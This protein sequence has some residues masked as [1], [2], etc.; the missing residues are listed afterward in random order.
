MLT[1]QLGFGALLGSVSRLQTVHGDRLFLRANP[2]GENSVVDPLDHLVWAGIRRLKGTPYRIDAPEDVGTC[3]KILKN[4]SSV[5]GVVTRGHRPHALHVLR[6]LLSEAL[7]NRRCIPRNEELPRNAEGCTIQHFRG[8]SPEVLF[9][10]R[11]Q[12]EKNGRQK[13]R[14]WDERTAHQ[15]SL[16]SPMPPFDH[17]IGLG[18]VRRRVD[19][20][21]SNP[22]CQGGEESGLE[23]GSLVSGD[24]QRRAIGANPVFVE[25]GSHGARLDV[26]E[27]DSNRPSRETINDREAITE[28]TDQRHGNQIHVYMVETAVRDLN[29]IRDDLVVPV[30]LSALAWYA[31]ARPA[32]R[33]LSNLWPNEL[34]SQSPG[35]NSATGMG[36]AVDHIEGPSAEA[37]G[38]VRSHDA[39]RDITPDGFRADGE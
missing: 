28:V 2:D 34:L 20:S 6:Q 27:W 5:L 21:S 31:L 39:S 15:S 32:E 14:P 26:L 9:V 7:W 38:K 3:R 16:E 4:K 22:L 23:L 11:A 29:V 33:V 10:R 8:G 24:S 25:G 30:D 12:T 37:Q 1:W 18:V 36:Q 17:S 35:S 13:L 19:P